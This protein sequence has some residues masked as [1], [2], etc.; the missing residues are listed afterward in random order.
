MNRLKN[1]PLVW[2]WVL[3]CTTLLSSCGDGDGILIFSIEDDVRLGQQVSAEV[4]STYRANGQL[5]ERN[6]SNANVRTAYTSLDRI[7][8]RVL[9]SGEVRYRN[10]FEWNV[11]IINDDEMLNAFATPGGYIYVYSG[12]VKFLEDE[13]HLAGVLAHEIA[14]A[15]RRH[16]VRQLQRDY[17]IALLLSVALGNDSGT[18]QQIAGQLAGQ[19]AGL[20]FSREAETEADNMS[21]QYLGGTEHYACDGAAGFFVKLN[22]EEQGGRTPE[23]LSTHPNPENR[24]QNIQQ[25][26]QDLGCKTTS[27]ADT[28]F[29]ALKNALNQ[30]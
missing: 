27:A 23:F 3:I 14:H 28:D 4:D 17:G 10:E 22:Q 26:A 19:F 5:L 30:L 8:N 2:L 21:V 1:M 18:L 16:S 12:L 24:I 9:D 29:N 7:V 15:D 20:R 6:S 11:K 25:Q 13:D